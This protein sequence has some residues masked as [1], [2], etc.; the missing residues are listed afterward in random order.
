MAR[1]V[2][3]GGLR[4][5]CLGCGAC[6]VSHG[7]ATA[8]YVTFEDRR[9]LA[10]HLGV[11]VSA[12]TRKHCRRLGAGWVLRDAEDGQSCSFLVARRCRVHAA[13]PTQCRTWPFWPE[14]LGGG[15]WKPEAVACCP[16]AG[17]GRVHPP[18][19]VRQIAEAQRR[20]DAVENERLK[21]LARS[22]RRR[23]RAQ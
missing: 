20:A 11:P 6:C 12:F 13:R 9:R 4:F 18:R 10:G 15:R 22:R 3:P 19:E 2:A 16:G 23:R 1:A 8:V 7:E 21:G 5:R 14:L 17:K